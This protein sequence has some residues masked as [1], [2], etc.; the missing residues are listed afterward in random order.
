MINSHNVDAIVMCGGKGTRLDSAVEKPLYEIAGVPM[1]DRVASALKES[2]ID[3]IYAAISPHSPETQAYVE[4]I[5]DVSVIETPGDGYLDDALVAFDR[6][7]GP[8]LTVAAD[9]PLMNGRFIDELLWAYDG[10]SLGCYTPVALNEQL[11]MNVN[12]PTDIGGYTCAATGLDITADPIPDDI[13]VRRNDNIDPDVKYRAFNARPAVNVN[14]LE[15][16]R[17][18]ERLLQ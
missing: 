11:E 15:Q 10:N 7:E 12:H 8:A 3:T 1:I 4:D 18:A 14:T 13:E 17:V 5:D 9:S 2:S 16:A 6:V